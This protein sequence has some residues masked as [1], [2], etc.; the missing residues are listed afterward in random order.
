MTR[1]YYDEFG[2]AEWERHKKDIPSRVSLEVHKRFLERFINPGD[3]VLEIGADPGRFTLE[4]INLG[5]Q[6]A[7]TN[8]SD[9]QLDLNRTRLAGSTS[10][11]WSSLP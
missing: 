11:E 5:A 6:V 3:R 9:V 1:P 10:V 2:N 4:L 8:F 7:V